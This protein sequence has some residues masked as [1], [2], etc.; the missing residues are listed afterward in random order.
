MS[1]VLREVRSRRDL[2]AF[3]H[4][5]FRLYRGN[6]YW[7]PPLLLDEWNT[8]TANKNPAFR[9][10]KTRF[11]LAE[12]KGRIVGRVLGIINERYIEKW[13][14]R[15]C[16]FGWL[17][18][19]DDAEVSSA[20]MGAVEDWARSAG[21]SAVHGPLG[22]TDLDRE[23]MLIEGFQEQG[24]MST[25]YNH[26]YY[27]EHLE[28][29]GYG[30]D[31]D[32]VEFHVR[33]PESIP[34]KA[35]RVGELVLK[36]SKLRVV[37]WKK[38]DMLGYARR[39]F[40]LVNESYKD[41]YGVVELTDEQ[42]ETYTKQYF[43]FM[44]PD[45]AKAVVDENDTLVAFGVSMPS[46]SDALQ[47]SRG[48]LF[49][50]GFLHLLRALRRPHQLDMLLVAVKPEYQSRGL[51]AILMTEI[52]RSALRNGVTDAETNPELESNTQVQAIWK[53]Y[54]A[55]R[56]KRRRCYIKQLV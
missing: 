40:E 55:R 46:L 22:F 25:L 24:T 15:Y 56:H 13:G 41:L 38:K 50:V 11:L 4:L 12:K 53:H 10:C 21:L 30:K 34:E 35:I 19:E 9:H 5:P 1:V 16:R 48:R 18:F 49:P 37:P 7:I 20:L 39:I 2:R 45:Y 27:P 8:L 42:I 28:R 32:W 51:P 54:D 43:G 29:L 3:I 31:V 23:G 36:R 14:N 33:V 52:N 26:P 17:D 44:N 6:P 47:K